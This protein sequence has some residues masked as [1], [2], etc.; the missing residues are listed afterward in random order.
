M[1]ETPLI[2]IV[3]PCYNAEDF[4][5][6]TLDAVFSQSYQNREIICVDDGSTD[7]TLD[8]LYQNNDKITILSENN[9]GASY[10]RNQGLYA[11][12]GEYIQF[13]DADDILADQKLE[14]Q[15]RLISE[16]IINE[17]GVVFGN[18]FLQSFNNECVKK[19]V[20]AD[21]IW[22][23]LI[24]GKIGITSSN[25]YHRALI[26]AV[27]GWNETL[28]SSQD[29]ELTF[30]I[31]QR[32]PSVII[33]DSYNTTVV[34]IQSSITNASTNKIGNLERSIQLRK[35]IQDYLLANNKLNAKRKS[36]VYQML[37]SNIKELSMYD[38][39]KAIKYFKEYLPPNY[40]PDD[41]NINIVYSICYKLLGFA[42]TQ[43]LIK[44]Y[45][46]NKH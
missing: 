24:K 25:L 20:Y 33:D 36:A 11:S 22:I 19:A 39:P 46:K 27:G 41:K 6:N 13:L 29:T 45:Q 21:D 9:H 12:K 15:I 31:L 28:K 35:Q 7:N 16:K 34:Q 1:S 30:R 44:L 5:Q 10:A 32:S 14:H 26:M 23:A 8:I 18:Y 42:R 2:S 37:F 4:L 43:K 17:K 3:I 40:Y 38:L